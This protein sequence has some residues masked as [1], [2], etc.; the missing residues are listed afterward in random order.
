MKNIKSYLIIGLSAVL[1]LSC[2]EEYLD[3]APTDAV[4]KDVI[5]ETTQGAQ[6]AING[7]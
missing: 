2:S 4:S 5:F 7:M 3:T 6:V 1:L